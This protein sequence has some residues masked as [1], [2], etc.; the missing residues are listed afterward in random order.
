MLLI[1]IHCCSWLL[2]RHFAPSPYFFLTSYYR[3]ID[4]WHQGLHLSSHHDICRSSNHK[5]NTCTDPDASERNLD[6]WWLNCREHGCSIG[7]K[8]EVRSKMAIRMGSRIETAD[9]WC[10]CQHGVSKPMLHKSI[11]I[12]KSMQVI[13]H[14]VYTEASTSHDQVMIYFYHG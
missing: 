2:P 1:Y 10:V 12:V 9:H 4:P 8:R 5:C 13:N 7:A 11:N 14:T 3:P 6:A